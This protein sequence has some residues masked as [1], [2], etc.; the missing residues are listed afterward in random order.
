MAAK[1]AV[2]AKSVPEAMRPTRLLLLALIA[3]APLLRAADPAWHLFYHENVLG[4]SL[5]LRFAAPT[6]ATAAAAETAALV[7]IDRLAKILSTYD[8]TSEFRQWCATQDEPRRVSTELFD[9][10]SLFDAWRERTG[11]ALNASAAVA[12][13]LWQ[14]AAQAK[15]E[16]SAAKLATAVALA[17][18][19]HWSLDPVARMATHLTNA[20]L[21][22]NSFAKSYII[23]RA[24]SAALAAGP[25]TG[26]IV[27]LGGDIVMRGDAASTVAL[28]DPA[29]DA[30]ND[31]PLA[32][33]V[34]RDRAIATSGGYR[35]GVEI[36]GRHYSHLLDPRTALPVDHVRSATVV[37]PRA[38][39]AGALATALCVLPTAEGSRLAD[40]LGAE[41][42]LVLADGS[43]LTSA[44]WRSLEA[45]RAVPQVHA[46]VAN[47]SAN[48]SSGDPAS[49][50]A[51]NF[52]IAAPG[53][54]RAKR[55]FVAVWVEDKDH[56]PVRTIALWY[57]GNR[58]LPDLRSWI[59]ADRLRGL[60]D[61]TEIAET[62]ASA[63]RGPGKYTV[64][65]DG[66]DAAGKAL[67]PGTYTLFL[68]IAREHGTHQL[69]RH[70]VNFT[71]PAHV[72]FAANAELASASL[73]YRRKAAA[74]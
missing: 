40:Q 9:V 19:K 46:A 1:R 41:W 17:G 45:P 51:V 11:G 2:A 31:L 43:Q 62:I 3:I 66:K 35:R 37:A 70:E 15:R 56:F 34:A 57:H 25:L 39:D 21:V 64:K 69:I 28:A 13:R 10:L 32:H 50:I 4:T 72:D 68:E 58:W 60:A 38:T 49:E 6:A 7:E 20:P 73:D 36:A 24:C 74:R 18:E 26:A 61:G 48:A 52:E 44:G 8:S 55:P 47:S 27:N 16:P 33:L 59:N 5:E 67:T 29:A 22:L 23:D 53:G 71:G 65:W 12:G 54:G 30:E 14:E 42:L 63:T